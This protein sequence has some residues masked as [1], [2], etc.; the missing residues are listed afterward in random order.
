MSRATMSIM[1]QTAFNLAYLSSTLPLLMHTRAHHMQRHQTCFG[2]VF[3][4]LLFSFI[5]SP[6]YST[7]AFAIRRTCIIMAARMHC[8]VGC[9]RSAIIIF[10]VDFLFV[11]WT[12]HNS[13]I[14]VHMKYGNLFVPWTP[15]QYTK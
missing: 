1:Q 5:L 11:E 14:K 10:S 12:K 2:I 6:Y 15:G 7:G 13:I 3:V 8:S 9:S 4:R